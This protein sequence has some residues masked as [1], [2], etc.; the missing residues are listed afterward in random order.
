MS[1]ADELLADLEEDNDNDLDELL[2]D[3]DDTK[4]EDEARKAEE[5]A[6]KLL[7]PSINLMEVDVKVQ[8][9]RE[10]CKLRDSERLQYVL[11]Q[12][13]HYASRHRSA[14]EML[15]SVE[16]DPEYQLIVE[17]NAIAVD[18]DNEI[19]MF[20]KYQTPKN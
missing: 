3:V 7:K 6:E 9:I 13:E 15:G 17:A 2:K 14:A 18:I 1:L 8:S 11:R 5:I 4:A 10:V 12:I 20:V 19:C 16:S